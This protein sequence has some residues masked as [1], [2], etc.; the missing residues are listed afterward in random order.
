MKTIKI[1]PIITILASTLL[2]ANTCKYDDGH[3][4]ITLR[5][6]LHKAIVCQYFIGDTRTSFYCSYDNMAIL[7]GVW[8]DSARCLESYGSPSASE[9]EYYLDKGQIL[10]ILIGSRDMYEQYYQEPCDTFKKYVPVLHQ[11]LLTLEDLNRMNWT[12]VYPP[13]E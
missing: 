9:W 8:A 5:N 11:Y 7:D 12:V 6:R 4:C 2:L 3:N 13:E 10:N 1:I